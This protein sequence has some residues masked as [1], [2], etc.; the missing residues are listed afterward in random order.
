[1]NVRGGDGGLWGEIVGSRWG[2]VVFIG[3]GFKLQCVT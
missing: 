2:V 1:M 3:C